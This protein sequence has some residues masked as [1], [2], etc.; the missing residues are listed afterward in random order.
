MNYSKRVQSWLAG[1]YAQVEH[2]RRAYDAK[3]SEERR[4]DAPAFLVHS[5]WCLSA[6][7]W[8]EG[9]PWYVVLPVFVVG[10]VLL[11]WPSR[12]LRDLTAGRQT[13]VRL[14]RQVEATGLLPYET[15]VLP[16]SPSTPESEE[17]TPGSG[18]E[19]SEAEDSWTP[20]NN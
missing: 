6:A 18:E 8:W 3:M 13:L 19:R 1:A 16:Y 7:I 4:Q 9:L 20:R 17:P 12:E 2:L 15:G 10:S 14:I 11:L 5:A